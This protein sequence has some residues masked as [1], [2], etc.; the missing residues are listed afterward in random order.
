L[1]G[2]AESGDMFERFTDGA[3]NAVVLA[4][5]EALVLRHPYIGTEHLLLGLTLEQEGLAARVLASLGITAERVREH[6]VRIVSTANQVSS[7]QIPFTP[8]AKRVL[9]LA[10]REGLRFGTN[11]IA[12]EHILLGLLGEE[13]GGA[14]GILVELEVEDETIRTQLVSRLVDPRSEPGLDT[15]PGRATRHPVDQS[16]FGA[17]GAHVN[18]LAKE[19]RRDLDRDPDPG[20]LLI[21][22]ARAPNTLVAAALAELGV[23]CAA[24]IGAVARARAKVADADRELPQR[25]LEVTREKDRAI[26]ARDLQQADRLREQERDLT[27]RQRARDDAVLLPEVLTEIRRSL[28]IQD[29]RGS[30]PPHAS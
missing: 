6:V 1:T 18:M 20:D 23:D 9:E 16:W 29:Q 7:E 22:L 14:V 24:L 4:R 11:Q 15:R 25:I 19:I 28:H 21:A 2:R 12:T 8:H 13:D 27:R 30:Q 26:E 3:R 10:L 5:M 17:L